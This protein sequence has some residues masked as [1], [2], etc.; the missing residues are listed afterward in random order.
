MSDIQLPQIL[1]SLTDLDH[2][3]NTTAIHS[4][5][6]AVIKRYRVQ[7]RSSIIGLPEQWWKWRQSPSTTF[8]NPGIATSSMP[9]T[10]N[11]KPHEMAANL[12]VP[13]DAYD[14]KKENQDPSFLPLAHP[15]MKHPLYFT[16]PGSLG[17][18]LAS[19]NATLGNSS[20]GQDEPG[21]CTVSWPP[22]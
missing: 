13:L 3:E 20:L 2:W 1:N 11:D 9:G 22:T 10:E 21:A 4:K 7:E 12:S 5:D 16:N 8:R 19:D 18:E 6:S 17:Q 15:N 14:C